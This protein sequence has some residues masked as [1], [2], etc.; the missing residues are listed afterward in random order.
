MGGDEDEGGDGAEL[1]DLR[2]WPAPTAGGAASRTGGYPGH[3][4]NYPHRRP[5]Q[6]GANRD[7]DGGGDDGAVETSLGGRRHGL[8]PL[9]NGARVRR[10]AWVL[11]ALGALAVYAWLSLDVLPPL[12]HAVVY[13]WVTRALAPTR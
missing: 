3:G 1:T 5:I 2:A 8:P 13:S 11:L 7:G 10:L 9:C 4:G 6:Y 12:H